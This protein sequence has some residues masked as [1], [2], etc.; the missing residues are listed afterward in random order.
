MKTTITVKFCSYMGRRVNR[1]PESDIPEEVKIAEA[2]AKKAKRT[3]RN[4]RVLTV[5]STILAGLPFVLPVVFFINGALTNHPLPIMM[6][7]YLVLVFYPLAD[8]GGLILY[9]GS[10]NANC[11]RKP[12]GWT[13]LATALLPTLAAILFQDY[14]VRFDVTHFNRPVTIVVFIA[15]LLTLLCM[16]TLCVFAVLLLVRV[17]PKQPKPE[18]EA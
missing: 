13:A 10:R 3:R 9:I 8:I 18:P 4:S 15:L 16:I 5:W 2:E 7:P 1:T 17:F 11:L 12:I 14:L 6:Y